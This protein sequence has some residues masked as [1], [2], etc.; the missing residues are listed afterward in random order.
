MVSILEGPAPVRPLRASAVEP[1]DAE[2]K[3]RRRAPSIPL[4]AKRVE[5]DVIG[6]LTARSRSGRLRS[7][8]G[9]GGKQAAWLPLVSLTDPTLT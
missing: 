4:V 1:P 8:G 7:V 5:K 2:P 3:P 6:V 9:S